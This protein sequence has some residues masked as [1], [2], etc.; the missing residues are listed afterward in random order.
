MQRKPGDLPVM[1]ICPKCAKEKPLTKEFFY[2]H[3]STN[4]G[5]QYYCK[6]CT[7]TYVK[8]WQKEQPS[9]KKKDDSIQKRRINKITRQLQSW[10]PNHLQEKGT[11]YT[12]QI[13]QKGR[14]EIFF[15]SSNTLLGLRKK[16]KEAGLNIKDYDVTQRQLQTDLKKEL[17]LLIKSD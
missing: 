10:D 14:G 8:K 12:L 11:F 7:K 9:K 5:F 13:I 3:T 2:T 17:Q 6:E 4:S 15:N 16:V 1:K